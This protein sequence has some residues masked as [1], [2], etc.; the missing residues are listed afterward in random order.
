MNPKFFI[1]GTIFNVGMGLTY[2]D[3]IRIEQPKENVLTIFF[4]NNS[5]PTD[6]WGRMIETE[7]LENGD[8]KFKCV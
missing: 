2:Y 7:V 1:L 8:L 5:F 4:E 3:T 6:V